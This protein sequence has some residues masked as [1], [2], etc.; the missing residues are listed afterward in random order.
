MKRQCERQ[1]SVHPHK[2]AARR[3]ALHKRVWLTFR[4][5]A[6]YFLTLTA[7]YRRDRA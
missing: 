6:D 7:T 3:K 5:M 1:S 4:E 2:A